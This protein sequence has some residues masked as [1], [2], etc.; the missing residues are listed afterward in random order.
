MKTLKIALLGTALLVGGAAY[1]G[2]PEGNGNVTTASYS[3]P[4]GN[5]NVTTASYTAPQGNGNVTTAYYAEPTTARSEAT[6]TPVYA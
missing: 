4:Q 5:G 3:A 1:A 6:F 2:A